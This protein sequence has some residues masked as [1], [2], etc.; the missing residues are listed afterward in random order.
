MYCINYVIRKGDTLYGISRHYNIPVEAIINANPFINVYNLEVGEV[1][2]LPV[3]VP[4]NMYTNFTTYL[5][6]AG[7]TL[8]SIIERNGMNLA[9]LIELNDMNS[10]Y[11]EPGTILQIPIIDD[12]EDGITL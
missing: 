9:D 2:C 12:S 11:L 3:G 5:V 8:G 1:L 4:Q 10:I 6:E 7:D